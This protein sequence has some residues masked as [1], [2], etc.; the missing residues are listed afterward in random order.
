METWAK[1]LKHVEDHTQ[2]QTNR[3]Q[4]KWASVSRHCDLIKRAHEK[5]G[6]RRTSWHDLCCCFAH[7]SD[8]RCCCFRGYIWERER[9]NIGQHWDTNR[10]QRKKK[11][12]KP[13]HRP[14]SFFFGLTIWLSDGARQ[15]AR[16][17]KEGER[18]KSEERKKREGEGERKEGKGGGP[19]TP[20]RTGIKEGVEK[21]ESVQGKGQI[22]WKVKKGSK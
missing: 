21:A 9:G 13:S 5:K 22:S 11:N 6:G 14:P 17:R 15:R 8:I 18:F 4:R 7:L 12:G 10:W 16:E 1:G 20:T 3:R 19:T 2:R